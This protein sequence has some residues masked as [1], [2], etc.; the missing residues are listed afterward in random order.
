VPFD[1]V[2]APYEGAQYGEPTVQEQ[3]SFADLYI[4]PEDTARNYP[5]LLT[6]EDVLSELV[7]WDGGHPKH[8]ILSPEREILW[9]EHGSGLEDTTR[10]KVVEFWQARR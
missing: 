3:I 8:C 10:D 9:C 4:D 2:L 6:D 7:P 5:I 1:V